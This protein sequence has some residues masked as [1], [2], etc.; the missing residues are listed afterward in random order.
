MNLSTCLYIAVLT[1]AAPLRW[2]YLLCSQQDTEYRQ[3]F[4]H[5][6]GLDEM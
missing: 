6:S 1:F 5:D 4:Q 2:D 3:T